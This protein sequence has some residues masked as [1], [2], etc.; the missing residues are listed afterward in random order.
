MKLYIMKTKG[1]KTTKESVR[2]RR[3]CIRLEEEGEV[4]LYWYKNV[5]AFLSKKD[6]LQYCDDEDIHLDSIDIVTINV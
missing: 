5:I 4:V 1:E 6:L 2:S 3:E